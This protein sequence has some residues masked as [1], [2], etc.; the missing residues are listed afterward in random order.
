MTSCSN[1]C[2]LSSTKRRP[3]GSVGVEA[4][5]KCRICSY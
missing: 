5:K 4:G 1:H 2:T 3:R